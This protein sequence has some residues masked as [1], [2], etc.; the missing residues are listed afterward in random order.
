MSVLYY[1]IN[2]KI[3][4]VF[5]RKFCFALYCIRFIFLLEGRAGA[6]HIPRQQQ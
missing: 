1:V 3:Y 2:K 5:E 6:R 4:E